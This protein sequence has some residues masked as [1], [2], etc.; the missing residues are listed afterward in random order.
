[1]SVMRMDTRVRQTW[2][3]IM[4]PPLA[5]SLSLGK[6]LNYLSLRS[7]S[8]KWKYVTPTSQIVRIKMRQRSC[9]HLVEYYTDAQ[10]TLFPLY[11]R[12]RC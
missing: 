10:R 8:V 4:A 5:T 2:V 11:F 9:E 7:F 1:M 12:F 3:Q 6:L